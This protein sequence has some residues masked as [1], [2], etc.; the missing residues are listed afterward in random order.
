MY[1]LDEGN[2]VNEVVEKE[3]DT[4]NGKMIVVNNRIAFNNYS[5]RK[6]EK[7]T[8]FVDVTF[9]G[10]DAEYLV[11]L[12]AKNE[13]NGKGM[14]IKVGGVFYEEEWKNKDTGKSGVNKRIDPDF[15]TL[16]K[17][18]GTNTNQSNNQNSGNKGGESSSNKED[19]IFKD[20][21]FEFPDELFG[22]EEAS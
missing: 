21:D 17:S 16:A 12:A 5:K 4:A 20:Q 7:V 3:I 10:E 9:I 18:R 13:K 2:L 14:A 6:K 15:V 22:E 8:T 19:A 11:R 1:I